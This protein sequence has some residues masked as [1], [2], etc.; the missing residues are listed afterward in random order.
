MLQLPPHK[1]VQD[2]ITRW[3][4]SYDMITRYLEQQAA[5]YSA[6]AEKDIK[7]NAKDLIT[8]SENIKKSQ[9]SSA[10]RNVNS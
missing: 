7:K 9:L 6:L 3:N 8:L 4:S 2:V 10:H 5:V 1:L